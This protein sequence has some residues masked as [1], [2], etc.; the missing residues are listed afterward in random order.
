MSHRWDCPDRWQAEREGERAHEYG[1]G[2]YANPY[3]ERYLPSWE[4]EQSCPE[5]ARAWEDGHRRAE[6]REEEAAQERAAQARAKRDRAEADEQAYY[7]Q[8]ALAEAEAN[9]YA[10][11]Q[12]QYG[13]EDIAEAERANRDEP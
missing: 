5:A 12:E 7:E 9:Y 3:D 8:R 11:Q 1:R 4:R 2:R 6:L 13:A 10:M